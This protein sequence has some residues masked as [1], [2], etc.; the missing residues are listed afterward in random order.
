MSTTPPGPLSR[1][2]YLSWP[3][4]P[5]NP[6]ADPNSPGFNPANV[7]PSSG[8][9][10]YGDAALDAEQYSRSIERLHGS[11]LHGA[12]V[13]FGMQVHCTIG[14]PNVTILPGVA[15]DKAGRHIYLS[16]GGQ[17]EIGPTASTPNTPPDLVPV[18][19][20]G[21]VFPTAGLTGDHYVAVQWRETWDSASYASD[22]NIS[23]YNDTPWLQLI[24]AAGYNPDVHVVLGKVS[25]DASGKITAASYGDTAGLQRSSVSVPAQ[26]LELRRAVN[27]ATPGAD[28]APWGSV[29]AREA[30]GIEIAVANTGDEVAM[31]TTAG[32]TFST[33]AV[34]ANQANFGAISAPGIFLKGYE[35]TI[36]VGAPGNYGD[37]L[38]H[39]GHGNLAVSLV[40]DTGHVV[41]GG[42]SLNGEIRMK[43]ANAADTMTLEGS[44]GSAVLQRLKPFTSSLTIDVDSRFFK[45]HGWDLVLDGRS[46]GGNRALV[47]YDNLLVMNFNGDY[48]NGVEVNGTG[49]KVD[50]VLRDGNNIPLMGNPARKALFN[51]LF[52][53][54]NPQRVTV[55]VDIGYTTAFTAYASMTMIN[56]TTD[57]DY[58]NGVSVEVYKIDGNPTSNTWV[59]GGGSKWGNDGDDINAHQP[60]VTGVGRV[61]TFRLA[62]LGPDI[63]AA[64]IGIVFYE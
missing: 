56:S 30:G 61:I 54:G 58:D 4:G 33:L 11:G 8:L 52:T 6:D 37:V 7:L 38:V 40:G 15:L 64:A 1:S 31:L 44:N 34:G 18:A 27:T 41:V 63:N 17:A 29:R 26:S 10:S 50:G 12:G 51:Y 47:D 5:Y 49:L 35:A 57:F 42:P 43:N 9:V 25:L 2:N 53:N 55:D 24:T 16:V 19:A 60:M 39:D 14:Q 46:G 13:G 48:K 22:P 21:A 3:P 20:G 28:S 23:Q 62:A 59:S 32:G 45:I 36:E